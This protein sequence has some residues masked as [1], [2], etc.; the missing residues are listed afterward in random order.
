LNE[1]DDNS[2]IQIFIYVKIIKDLKLLR[3][4]LTTCKV[5]SQQY[6][7]ESEFAINS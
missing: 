5:Q 2:L 6:T 1:K 4:Y 7:H 3:D